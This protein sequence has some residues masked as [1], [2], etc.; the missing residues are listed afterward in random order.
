V[1]YIGN[2]IKLKGFDVLVEALTSCNHVKELHIAG[3]SAS[4]PAVIHLLERIPKHIKIMQYGALKQ[5]QLYDLMIQSDL[6]VIPARFEALGVAV[7]ESLAQSIPTLTTGVG[8][9]KEVLVDYPSIFSDPQNVQPQHLAQ[10]IE[11]VFSHYE[12]FYN[13]TFEKMADI[14][15]RFNPDNM[16]RAIENIYRLEE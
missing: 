14:R 10:N 15:R 1:L 2:N 7:I 4:S 16:M 6:V 8:G 13:I 11:Q 9:L 5:E 12:E 3:P